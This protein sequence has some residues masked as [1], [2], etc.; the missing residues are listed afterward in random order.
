MQPP[1]NIDT[2]GPPNS[3]QFTRMAGKVLPYTLNNEIVSMGEAVAQPVGPVWR[4][5]MQDGLVAR[6]SSSPALSKVPT[7]VYEP[8]VCVCLCF[9]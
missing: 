5:S 7:Y 4:K 1:L 6:A 8:F 2:L 3:T 9:G